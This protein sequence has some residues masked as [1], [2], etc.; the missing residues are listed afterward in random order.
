MDLKSLLAPYSEP[1]EDGTCLRTIENQVK[2]LMGKNIPRSHI[3]QA[4][5]SVYDEIER[6]KT[7]ENGTALDHYLLE[8][9]THLH[10]VELTDSVAKLEAFFSQLMQTH[11]D[12]AASEIIAKMQRPLNWLQRAAKRLFRL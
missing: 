10:K 7:F 2:W 3:D 1:Q 9:A 4:I 12:A 8:V 11:R 5:L 6:G